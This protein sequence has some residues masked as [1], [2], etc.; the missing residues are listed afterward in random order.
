[1]AYD[2]KP[3]VGDPSRREDLWEAPPSLA[4]RKLPSTTNNFWKVIYNFYIGLYNR[5]VQNDGFGSQ[6]YRQLDLPA[7]C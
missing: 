3:G 4:I 7:S 2:L 6:S 1:M 5:N